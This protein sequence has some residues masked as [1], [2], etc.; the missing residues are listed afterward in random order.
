MQS[1]KQTFIQRS[2][3]PSSQ[4]L[5]LFSTATTQHEGPFVK[6]GGDLKLNSWREK[7]RRQRLGLP[8]TQRAGSD[9]ESIDSND[10]GHSTPLTMPAPSQGFQSKP[11]TSKQNVEQ[12]EQIEKDSN[13]S[14]E[15]VKQ[16]PNKRRMLPQVHF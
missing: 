14:D 13:D 7:V 2:N 16:P 3:E 8:T 12:H 9:D 4:S 10:S 5:S 6:K 11:K 15:E 1:Q